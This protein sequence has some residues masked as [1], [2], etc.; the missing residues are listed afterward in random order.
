MLCRVIR[1]VAFEDLGTFASPLEDAGFRI[2]YHDIGKD[3]LGALAA[4]VDDLMVVLGGPIGACEDTRYPFLRT[5]LR[6]I[7]RR[8]ESGRPLMGICLGAQ[9]IARAFGARVYRSAGREIGFAPITLTEAGRRSCLA[10][11]R[12]DPTTL[13]WHGDTFDLPPGTARLASTAVCENQA[14]SA[15]ANVIGLQ[16]HPEID[17]GRIEQWLIGHTV[18]LASSGIDVAQ[19][20]ADARKHRAGLATKARAVIGTWLSQAG[21]LSPPRPLAAALQGSARLRGERD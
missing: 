5:E 6:I 20:R 15:G 21:G 10:P 3:E 19:I 4:D 8:I 13:H 9:L 2:V 16:F 7:E 17:A 11:F 1:H 18:E 12:D 14:F